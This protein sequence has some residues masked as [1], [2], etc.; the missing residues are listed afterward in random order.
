MEFR[1]YDFFEEQVVRGAEVYVLRQILNDWSDEYA[2][3]VLRA[4]ILALKKGA[5]VAINDAVLPEHGEVHLVQERV[6]REAELGM[7]K[8]FNAKER[9]IDHWKALTT[10]ADQRFKITKIVTPEGSRLSILEVTW[11]G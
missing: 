3:R 4:L 9:D 10:G 1:V 11:E 6:R 2:T 8:L 5:K 7:W